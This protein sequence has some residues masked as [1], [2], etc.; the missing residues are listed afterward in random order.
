[1]RRGVRASSRGRAARLKATVDFRP[2]MPHSFRIRSRGAQG[3]ANSAAA[4]APVRL[5]PSTDSAR[6]AG[7]RAAASNEADALDRRCRRIPCKASRGRRRASGGA[8]ASGGGGLDAVGAAAGATRAGAAAATAPHLESHPLG[9]AEGA[10]GS[11]SL[12]LLHVDRAAAG[13]EGVARRA[14]REAR[15]VRRRAVRHSG[16]RGARAMA[17]ATVS[18]ECFCCAIRTALDASENDLARVDARGSNEY[19]KGGLRSQ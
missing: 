14:A 19:R 8:W 11:R 2:P 17:R 3:A 10:H 13:V 5:P 16:H 4:P 15:G 1:M 7:S 12:A 6:S 9:R 18:S